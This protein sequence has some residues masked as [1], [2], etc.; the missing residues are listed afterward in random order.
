M[1]PSP[2]EFQP[3]RWYDLQ[4]AHPE[5][6]GRYQLPGIGAMSLSFGH[7]RHACP[8]RFL[9]ANIMKSVLAYLLA[10][11]DIKA[12]AEWKGKRIENVQVGDQNI[13]DRAAMIM[14]RKRK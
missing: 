7:G 10:N 9:A 11:Y 6:A 5:N 2:E 12:P 4:K 14:M 1:F 3:F 13:P 8:G